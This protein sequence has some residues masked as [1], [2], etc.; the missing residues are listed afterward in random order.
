LK[1]DVRIEGHRVV[2]RL[3]G[4]LTRNAS[5]SAVSVLPLRDAPSENEGVEALQNRITQSL[6]E[7]YREIVLDVK[8]VEYVDS[9]GLG[10]IVGLHTSVTRQGG[11]CKIEGLDSRLRN[12]FAIGKPTDFPWTA[13]PSLFPSP[14]DPDLNDIRWKIVVAAGLFVVLIMFVMIVLRWGGIFDSR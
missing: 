10:V 11:V 6:N 5:E 13:N 7:G 3:K 9:A 1:V 2:L 8:D 12:V 4:H 14:I